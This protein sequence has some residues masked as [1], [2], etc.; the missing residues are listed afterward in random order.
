MPSGASTS[1]LQDYNEDIQKNYMS[2]RRSTPRHN[3]QNNPLYL[4]AF[5]ASTEEEILQY[6]HIVHCSL[7]AVEGKCM[8]FLFQKHLVIANAR[9]YN[10]KQAQLQ[11]LMLSRP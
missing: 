1:I 4:E 6:H 2:G 5:E 7:D 3:V 11:N 10:A 9:S 8:V